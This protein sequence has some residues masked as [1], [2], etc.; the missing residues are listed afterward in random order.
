MNDT[1][2]AMREML[3]GLGGREWQKA[4]HHRVY[5]P[6]E[7][8]LK[9]LGVRVSYYN[10][11]NVAAATRN[12]EKIS[13]SLSRDYIEQVDGTYYDVTADRFHGCGDVARALRAQ[14]AQNPI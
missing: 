13:N 12:G 1:A 3:L 11:G 10:S 5:I 14:L 2:N 9:L 7:L 4:A 8:G 6:K